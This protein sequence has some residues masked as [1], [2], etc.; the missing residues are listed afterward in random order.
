[1]DA[2]WHEALKDGSSFPLQFVVPRLLCQ[3]NQ[4]FRE[5][6]CQLEAQWNQI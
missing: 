5:D 4:T 2:K 6:C 1:M 3:K